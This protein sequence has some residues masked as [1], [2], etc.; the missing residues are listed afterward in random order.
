MPNVSGMTGVHMVIFQLFL[1]LLNAMNHKT[2]GSLGVP[3]NQ[4][5]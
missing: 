4:I 2:Y 5:P 1:S 3:P